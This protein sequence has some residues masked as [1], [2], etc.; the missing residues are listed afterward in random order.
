MYKRQIYEAAEGQGHD[1]MAVGMLDVNSLRSFIDENQ[2]PWAELRGFEEGPVH[3]E[4]D[5]QCFFEVLQQGRDGFASNWAPF[6]DAP[7]FDH[8][9][10]WPRAA[11]TVAVRGS[12]NRLHVGRS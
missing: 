2:L 3:L 9:H 5:A 10:G 8:A 1:T 6:P 4:V 7:I 11:M 12:K